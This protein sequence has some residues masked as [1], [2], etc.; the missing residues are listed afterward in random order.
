LEATPVPGLRYTRYEIRGSIANLRL[1]RP[2][3]R[4]AIGDTL[5]ADLETFFSNLRQGTE[6]VVIY[7]AGD[8]FCAGFRGHNIVPGS[9]G[10]RPAMGLPTAIRSITC[11]PN[12]ISSAPPSAA[13]QLS[14][15]CRPSLLTRSGPGSRLALLS[16]GCRDW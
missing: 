13:D 4:N 3:K 5:L 1:D 15:W 16:T 10:A 2:E 11:P 12:Q 9:V 8:H 7:G 14:A 6:A